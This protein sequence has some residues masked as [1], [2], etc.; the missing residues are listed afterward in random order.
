MIFIF[1]FHQVILV[2]VHVFVLK[3]LFT[4]LLV[5]NFMFANL[6]F[7]ELPSFSI[8][9]PPRRLLLSP[10]LIRPQKNR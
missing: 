1:C 2:S 4:D 9:P 5:N 8:P 7:L 3:V 6:A 10:R